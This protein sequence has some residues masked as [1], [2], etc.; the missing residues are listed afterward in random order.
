MLPECYKCGKEIQP[1]GIHQ[2]IT[3]HDKYGQICKECFLST[4][5]KSKPKVNF[6][7]YCWDCYKTYEARRIFWISIFLYIVFTIT[8]MIIYFLLIHR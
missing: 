5:E 1:E 8:Q 7:K 3:Y 4:K 2:I 6:F